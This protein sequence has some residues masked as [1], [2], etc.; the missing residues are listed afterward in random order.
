MPI[1]EA[2]GYRRSNLTAQQRKEAE[3]AIYGLTPISMQDTLE[4]T[5]AEIERMRAIVS[6][7]DRTN[8]KMEEIDLNNPKTPPYRYQKFP[9]M[10]YSHAKRENRIVRSE[11]EM[12]GFI[13]L[14]WVDVPY[15]QDEPE[16][17]PLDA[18]GAAEAAQVDQKLAELRAKKK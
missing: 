8:G 6:Q 10:I 16:P 4:L 14:G 15:P 5:A 18:A 11:D 2:S 9:K 12:Q 3:A 7:H 13:A 1:N 17:T